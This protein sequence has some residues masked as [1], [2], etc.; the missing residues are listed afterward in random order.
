MQGNVEDVQMVEMVVYVDRGS[1]ASYAP[2]MQY[3]Y[4]MRKYGYAC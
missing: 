3:V 1:S 2:D 4:T